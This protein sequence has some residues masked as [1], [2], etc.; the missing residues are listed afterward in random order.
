MELL[1]RH[2]LDLNE[3]QLA[4][5]IEGLIKNQVIEKFE[6]ENLSQQ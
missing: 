1:K 2:F 5:C 4:D 6:I 3:I